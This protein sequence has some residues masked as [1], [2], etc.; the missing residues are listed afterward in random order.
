[1]SYEGKAVVITGGLGFIGSNLAIR[2]ISAG[3]RV[4]II[5]SS[6][7]GCGANL[8]NIQPVADQCKILDLDIA[9]AHRAKDVIRQADIIFNLAGEVS[10]VHSMEFPERDLRINSLAHL[11]FLQVCARE[12]PA[13]RIV[14]AGTRQVYG[15]PKYLPVDEDHP[16]R[17]VDFNGV[18]K[19]AATMYHLI[20]ARM[21]VLD[22]VVIRLSNVYGPRMALDVPCQGFLSTFIRRL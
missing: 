8:H 4:S 2:L 5:D 17:P 20:F 12:A 7:P 22:A 16:V 13:I 11:R 15:I 9:D 6:E 1:M 3:A 10:H 19:F 18:H 14:Y 21:R